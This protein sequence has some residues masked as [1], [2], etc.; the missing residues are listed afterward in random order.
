MN[1]GYICDKC[2]ERVSKIDALVNN[3]KLLCPYCF[4]ILETDKFKVQ[5]IEKEQGKK[6]AVSDENNFTN[7]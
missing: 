2:L 3:N 7:K 4:H 6:E 1:N 5:E